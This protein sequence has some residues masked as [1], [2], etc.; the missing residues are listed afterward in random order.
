[1]APVSTSVLLRLVVVLLRGVTVVLA[2]ADCPCIPTE[3]LHQLFPT[4]DGSLRFS[5]QAALSHQAG[6]CNGCPGIRSP[7]DA[8]EWDDANASNARLVA[9]PATYGSST[10]SAWDAGLAP[11]CG[12]SPAPLWCSVPW[13]YVNA[14]VCRSSDKTMYR[15]TYLEPTPLFWSYDACSLGSTDAALDS[16]LESLGKSTTAAVRN[17]TLKVGIPMSYAPWHAKV[18]QRVED[19]FYEDDT[20]PY[21][22][23]VIDYMSHL[24]SQASLLGDSL[25]F[26]YTWIS[27]GS[28][29]QKSS[30]WT[31]SVLDVQKGL[32]D[33]AASDFWATQERLELAAF[34]VPIAVEL[35]YLWV[36]RPDPSN[37]LAELMKVFNPLDLTVWLCVFGAVIVVGW[38]DTA[39]GKVTSRASSSSTTTSSSAAASSSSVSSTIASGKPDDAPAAPFDAAVLHSPDDPNSGRRPSSLSSCRQLMSQHLHCDGVYSS[40]MELVGGGTGH[41]EGMSVAQRCL[42]F[43]WGFFILI[44]LSSYTANLASHLTKSNTGRFWRD[45]DDAT[46]DGARICITSALCTEA[47][48]R[49]PDASFVCTSGSQD[50]MD[51]VGDGRCEAM[52]FS[53]DSIRLRNRY[54]VQVCAD[55][56]LIDNWPPLNPPLNP[57][58]DPPLTPTPWAPHC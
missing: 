5:F 15:S 19:E 18:G 51:G 2:S 34:T 29:S 52:A 23:L 40:A 6:P 28:R 48:G 27:R 35:V 56:P 31:A 12:E 26:E 55:T 1:M 39:L 42:R 11:H 8:A 20:L 32:V 9:Y 38:V 47:R 7:I 16:F 17:R 21:E 41:D 3:H 49:W 4:V 45:V 13:C 54:G 53:L 10:C 25:E 50:A 30:R 33:M 44:L 14:S 22:G 36:P 37:P 24:R 58:S 43:T 46:A 57:P